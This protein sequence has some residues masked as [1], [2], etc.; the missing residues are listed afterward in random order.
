MT[1]SQIM[2][3]HAYCYCIYDCGAAFVRAGGVTG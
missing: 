1:L 2:I 3:Q